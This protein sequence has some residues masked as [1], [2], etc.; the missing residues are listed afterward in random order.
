[1]VAAK[2]EHTVCRVFFYL[3]S[4]ACTLNYQRPIAQG[5]VLLPQTMEIQRLG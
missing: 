2:G 5:G 1:M 4:S 3:H